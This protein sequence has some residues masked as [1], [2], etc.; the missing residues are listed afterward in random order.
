MT[1]TPVV[2]ETVAPT[3]IRELVEAIGTVRSS[4]ARARAG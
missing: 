1:P 4:G 2:V 3:T